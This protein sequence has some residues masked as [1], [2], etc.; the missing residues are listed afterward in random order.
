[1]SIFS[2]TIVVIIVAIVCV[3]LVSLSNRNIDKSWLFILGNME[4]AVC[5]FFQ[6]SY[7]SAYC[8]D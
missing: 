7:F 6:F 5:M 4:I 1:M 8:I 2:L 3:A